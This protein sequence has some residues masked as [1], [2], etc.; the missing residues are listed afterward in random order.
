MIY[1]CK[2]IGCWLLSIGLCFLGL[3]T[4]AQV[5]TS[6]ETPVNEK[7]SFLEKV[8]KS[9]SRDTATVQKGDDLTKDVAQYQ[10]FDGYI[11]RNIVIKDLP[12]GISLTDTSRKLESPFIKLGNELHHATRISAIRKNL[13]FRKNDSLVPFLMADN[14]AFLRQLPYMQDVRIQLLP[15]TVGGDSVDVYIYA[16]D[17]FTLGGAIYSLEPDNTDIAAR[18]D[19]VG[20]TGN[21]LVL[22]GLYDINRTRNFGTGI[23]YILRN[24]GGSFINLDARYQSYYPSITGLKEE[25]LYSLSFAKPLINRY[26]HWTYELDGSYHSTQNMYTNDSI[27]DADNNY[28]YY[29]FDTWVGYNINAKVFSPRAENLRLRKLIALRVIDQRFQQMPN[30]YD[31]VYNWRYSNLEGVLGSLTFYRQNIYKTKYLYAFGI[32][33]DVP[34][35]LTLTFTGGYTRKQTL[36]RPFISFDIESSTFNSRENYYSYSLRGEGYLYDKNLQDVN[37]FGALTYFD[38]LKSIGSKWN[39][40]TFVNISIA[41]QINTLL[42]EP[43]YL[44]SKYALPEYRNGDV[45]GSFRGSASIESVFYSPWHL[46]SFRFAPFLFTDGGIFSP[47]SSN[48]TNI[49]NI[50]GGGLRTRNESLIFGTLELKGYYFLKKNVYNENW[51]VDISTNITFKYNS[52]LVRKP[53]FIQ[54]N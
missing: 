44:D 28:S 42:N 11:I 25:H 16:K 22:H 30:E 47:Y 48:S 52:Q 20:G 8:V 34:E 39:Q 29:D 53:D 24:I 31:T 2:K 9:I 1:C 13:F 38:H 23:E 26:M 5:D 50:V 43:L 21:A 10:L 6:K 45:G 3:K 17:I 12:F 41:K 40:R 35:G 32:N 7:K 4:F 27:Y 15:V 37:L 18:E 51:R 19:N 36:N 46:S 14:E 33:E 54:V 49:Y